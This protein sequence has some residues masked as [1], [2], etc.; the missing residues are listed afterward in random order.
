MTPDWIDALQRLAAE[1]DAA[2]FPRFRHPGGDHE[3]RAGAILLLFAE[4]ERGLELVIIE[5]A[6]DMR[7]HAGQPAF[8]GGAIDPEDEGP[9]AAALREANEEIGLRAEEVTVIAQLPEL[10]VTPSNFLVTPV[11]AHWHAPSEVYVANEREVASVAR[12]LVA[13]LVNP[14]NRVR[15][16]LRNGYLGPAFLVEG[17]TVWG[18]TGGVIDRLL[19]LLAWSEPWDDTRVVDLPGRRDE[20]R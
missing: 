2:S 9:V 16:R 20:S 4:A 13:D 5:R 14:A 11:L 7:S 1:A 19:E 15:V 8:P 17:L 6:H 18:F 12:V 10:F 3:A